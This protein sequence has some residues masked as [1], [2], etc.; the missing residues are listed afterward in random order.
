MKNPLENFEIKSVKF[1]EDL[2]DETNCFNAK[3]YHKG[4][5]VGV[6]KNSGNGGETSVSPIPKSM[7]SKEINELSKSLSDYK[8][9]LSHNMDRSLSIETVA[10]LLVEQ[11]LFLKAIKKGF[12]SKTVGMID[13]EKFMTL[14][15]LVKLTPEL[16]KKV[17]D[18]YPTATILNELTDQEILGEFTKLGEYEFPE[19]KAA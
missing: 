19:F 10:D 13:K 5:L 1:C 7:N 2:S 8:W 11:H 17:K 16:L 15:C 3:L 6:A 18:K 14:N 12:K 9:V 4:K